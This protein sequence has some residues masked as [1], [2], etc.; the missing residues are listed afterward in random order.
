MGL[1]IS[2]VT[3]ECG[4]QA[5]QLAIDGRAS[6][7]EISRLVAKEAEQ[8]SLGKTEEVFTALHVAACAGHIDALERL[9]EAGAD[10]NKPRSVLEQAATYGQLVALQKL[11]EMGADCNPRGSTFSVSPLTAAT[12]SGHVDICEILLQAGADV[13]RSFVD[14]CPIAAATTCSNTK[15][16]ELFLAVVKVV[17]EELDADR[18]NFENAVVQGQQKECRRLLDMK[19]FLRRARS[20]LR[21]ALTCTGSSG[22]MPVLERLLDGGADVDAHAAIESAAGGG[23]LEMVNKL[24]QVESDQNN[25]PID[26]ITDA[27][28]SALDSGH[29][30]MIKPL[31]EA[32]ADIKDMDIR[33]AARDGHLGALRCIL[34]AGAS[35][36]IFPFSPRRG[37]SPLE[38]ALQLAAKGGYM[39][40]VD[41]LIS[42]GVNIKRDGDGAVR[43]AASGGHL[44]VVQ[45]LIEAGA[46][47]DDASQPGNSTQH[48]DTAL[49]AAVRAANM[50]LLDMLLA[51]GAVVDATDMTY[52]WRW[53]NK[54]TA[55]S[56]AAETNQPHLI[57]RLLSLMR[58]PKKLAQPPWRLCMW[59]SR[60][61]TSES[62]GSCCRCILMS[63]F[64]R[65]PSP[66]RCRWPQ[67]LA[68]WP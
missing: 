8:L 9:L 29:T 25:L 35:T 22:D 30:H 7:Q 59:L 60:S 40:I 66:L 5:L 21:H 1:D 14:N 44:L 55:L 63:T 57:T 27:L 36:N 15:L 26:S 32:G 37:W 10:P 12:M 19:G 23:H 39:E 4:R 11:L 33:R 3:Y 67:K 34:Q 65:E 62:C 54:V 38:S 50:P 53:S 48:L 16:L 68:T 46:D 42:N 51:A 17:A 61:A 28:Q 64:V 58:S 41:L 24:I 6:T 49:Q 20:C 52:S 43:S 2:N 13:T 47:V 45:R 56:I 18:G 31:L